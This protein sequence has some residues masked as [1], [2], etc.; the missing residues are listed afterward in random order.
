M[1][2]LLQLYVVV[3]LA[4]SLAGC[5]C[6]HEWSDAGCEAPAV[7]GKCNETGAPALGHAFTDASCAAPETC[8]RCAA[9]RGEALPH[10]FGKWMLN[11]PEMYRSCAICGAEERTPIDYGIYLHQVLPGQWDFASAVTHYGVMGPENLRWN[12]IGFCANISEDGICRVFNGSELFEA[13]WEFRDHISENGEDRDYFVLNLEDGSQALMCLLTT[14]SDQELHFFYD[15]TRYVRMK[16]SDNDQV[17][18]ALTACWTGSDGDKLYMLNLEKNRCLSGSINGEPISGIWSLGPVEVNNGYRSVEMKLYFA[19][20]GYPCNINLGSVEEPLEEYL[21]KLVFAGWNLPTFRKRDPVDV[22]KLEA[23]MPLSG[24]KLVGTWQAENLKVRDLKTGLETELPADAAS[25]EVAENGTY[26][27]SLDHQITGTWEFQNLD[28]SQ[29]NVNYYDSLGYT[30]KLSADKKNCNVYLW[31]AGMLNLS[32][33]DETSSLWGSFR[34]V[35]GNSEDHAALADEKLI[36]TWKVVDMARYQADGS[37]V[38]ETGFESYFLTAV[39]D[40][41]FQAWFGEKVRGEWYFSE[42]RY[43][44]GYCYGFMQEGAQGATVYH[45]QDEGFLKA[46]YEGANGTILMTMVKE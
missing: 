9:T 46:F 2:K 30:Y 7:C 42:Y 28:I 20:Q 31:G 10:S 34:K 16:K 12:A 44:D 39:K 43:T 11:D 22:M 38:E 21:E 18:A 19:Q 41:S 13:T 5:A 45:I 32:L 8:I 14:G 3:V 23:G 24:R 6:Q 29:S 36:G 15:E 35:S 33:D 27:L 26:V 17:A 40:G 1:K 37:Q 4:L 25:L